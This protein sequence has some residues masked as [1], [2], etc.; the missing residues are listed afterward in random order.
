MTQYEAL[1]LAQSAYGN[2]L[3]AYAVFVSIVSAYLATAYLVGSELSRVQVRLLTVLFLV[4]ISV[5]IWA[6]SAYISWGSVFATTALGES[7]EQSAMA[8]QSWV[9]ALMAVIDVLAVAASV[10]FM[11]N[12]R[13]NKQHDDI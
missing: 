3:A 11:W 1:D 8:P 6:V 12:V 13:H 2:S 5:V 4:V 9:P 7:F 10:Y